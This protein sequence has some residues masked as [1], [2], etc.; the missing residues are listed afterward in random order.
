[1]CVSG[2]FCT[3]GAMWD[4]GA[5]RCIRAEDCSATSDPVFLAEDHRT[6]DTRTTVVGAAAEDETQHAPVQAV[7]TLAGDLRTVAGAEGTV[8]P[9]ARPLTIHPL[10]LCALIL[11]WRTLAAQAARRDFRQAFA[12]DVASALS[13]NASRV[14]IDSI[15]DGSVVCGPT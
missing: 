13:I 15:T 10:C 4:G 2:Y 14:I 8:R 7:L 9:V 1:M 5:S 11:I 3:A 6:H 12:A